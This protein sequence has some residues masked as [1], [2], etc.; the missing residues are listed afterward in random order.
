[1]KCP[2]CR[3]ENLNDAVLCKNAATVSKH[4]EA[5]KNDDSPTKRKISSLDGEKKMYWKEMAEV[6]NVL[7]A[8]GSRVGNPMIFG[9]DVEAIVDDIVDEYARYSSE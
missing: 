5:T 3:S 6:D 8:I 2:K 9:A 7:L 4:S 1:M